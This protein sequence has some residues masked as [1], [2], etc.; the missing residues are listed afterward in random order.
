[1]CIQELITSHR[2]CDPK[3]HT[4]ITAH[5]DYHNSLL[6]FE[7]SLNPATRGTLLILSQTVTVS[8]VSP[9][10][11]KS[12][13]PYNNFQGASGL[14]TPLFHSLA[15]SLLY[16]DLLP[17]LQPQ[18]PSALSS[19]TLGEFLPQDLCTCSFCQ[20]CSLPVYPQD[21]F[22]TPSGLTA[23]AQGV[24]MQSNCTPPS[25]PLSPSLLPE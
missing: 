13:S 3:V 23:C 14:P 24:T 7:S 22:L 20:E 9:F 25:L 8:G 21:D 2:C 11:S 6:T 5:L 12:Q 16:S 10:L 15:S 1:M 4:P 19:S 18:W 17:L